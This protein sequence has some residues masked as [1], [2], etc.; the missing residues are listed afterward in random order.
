M[1]G[2]N[3][4]CMLG[5]MVLTMWACWDVWCSPCGHAGMCGV[6]HVCMLGMCGVNHVGML[7]MCGANHVGMLGCVVLTM[8]ASGVNQVCWEWK[9]AVLC[10]IP[11]TQ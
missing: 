8:C 2:V 3:H 5:C 10:A 1:W 11:V 7:G 4:V 9:G 6:N